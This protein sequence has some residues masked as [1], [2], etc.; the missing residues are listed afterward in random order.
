MQN[1]GQLLVFYISYHH[2]STI[3]CYANQAAN[4]NSPVKVSFVN[5]EYTRE[6]GGEKIAFN[7]GRELFMYPYKT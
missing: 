6:S 4:K 5:D 1:F 7:Y 3:P 2:L